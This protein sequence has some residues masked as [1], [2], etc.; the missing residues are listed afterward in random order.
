MEHSTCSVAS[1]SPPRH[2]ATLVTYS[3][4]SR[5]LF[6]FDLNLRE[7]MEIVDT[8]ITGKIESIV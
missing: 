8:C 7:D 5:I 1:C 4:M 6:S 3:N 2:K